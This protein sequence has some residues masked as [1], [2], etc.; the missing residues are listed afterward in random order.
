MADIF[1]L[2]RIDRIR[3]RPTKAAEEFLGDLRT[4]L[5][6]G[7]KATAAKLAISRSLIETNGNVDLSIAEGTERGMAI[8]GVHLFGD[9]ADLWACVIGIS[10]SSRIKTETD[11]KHLVEGHWHRGASLLK[12]DHEEVGK[13]D[14]DLVI[15][16]AGML[17]S[18]GNSGNRIRQTT[19]PTSRPV[20]KLVQT[21]ILA[22]GEKWPVNAPGG[23]G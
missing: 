13:N 3:Y 21:R 5:N 18:R 19:G 20:T 17:P 2:N 15:R 9:D 6:L 7:D 22:E 4:S 8:E 12:A 10:I 23:N 14:I 11:F 1:N 16:L